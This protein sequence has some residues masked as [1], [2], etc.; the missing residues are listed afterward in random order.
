MRSV[1]SLATIVDPAGLLLAKASTLGGLLR[2]ELPDGREVRARLLATDEETDLAL[3]HVN[4]RGLPAVE[5]ALDSV[6]VPGQ[7]VTAPGVGLGHEVGVVGAGA[8]EIPARG[9]GYL[10]IRLGRRGPGGALVD[11]VEPDSGAD[12]AG[13]REGD[14]VVGV[15]GREV[16]DGDELIS[17]LHL[18]APGQSVEVELVRDGS[19]MQLTAT[20]G[21]RPDLDQRPLFH[22]ADQIRV[23]DRRDRFPNAVRTDLVLEPD[24]CGGPLLDLEGRVVGLNIAR[25]DRVGSLALTA[26][27]VT[28]SLAELRRLAG[29]R[30]SF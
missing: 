5:F 12:R 1:E 25:V 13:F 8:R 24:H 26:S 19:R 15:N 21:S 11:W 23:S 28:D 4:A 14:R 18:H 3:L 7:F 27:A 17:T 30:R 2:A 20:L 29:A 16:Q 6:L 22:A 9:P 10:G